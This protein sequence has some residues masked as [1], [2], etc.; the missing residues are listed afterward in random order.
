M[1]RSL[2]ITGGAGFIGA[3]F[4]WFWAEQ[5]PEDAIVVVD[6]LTYAGSADNIRGLLDTGK[7]ALAQTDIRNEREIA[8]LFE[9]HGIDTVVHF[10]AES[11]VDRS[12][13]GPL[14][15]VS[16]NVIGTQVLLDCARRAWTGGS[17]NPAR[18]RFHHVSTDEVY[19][20]LG[21]DS[22]R[23][24]ET[25]SYAPRSPY[26]A[27]KAASDHLV[28]AYGNTY[29]LPWS[30]SNCSN[31]YGPYQYPEKLIP[32]A[33][34]N[35]LLGKRVPVYGNGRNVRDWLH[36][37]DH[38]RALEVILLSDYLRETFNVGGDAERANIDIVTQ[39]AQLVDEAIQAD[40]ALR[41][42]Y[43]HCPAATGGRCDSLIEFVRDRPG[44]DLRYANDTRKIKQMLGFEPAID[45]EHGL[46]KTLQWYLEHHEW[47]HRRLLEP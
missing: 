21:F 26:S 15:C 9:A 41:Q 24:T 20:S 19:G 8:Q 17:D 12:I 40:D 14:E 29:R 16:T 34:A 47:W 42:R 37:H 30:I 2:M 5:H 13:D 18:Y 39:L 28:R 22:P 25:T 44:H 11:H 36:V 3:N 6:M 1:S 45:L 27:S 32:L 4:T 43:K 33:L 23:F 46:A 35:M 7:V 10:A 38:C 31:N